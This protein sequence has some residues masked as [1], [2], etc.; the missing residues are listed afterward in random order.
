MTDPI[1]V[2]VV[3]QTPPPYHGQ[4]IMIQMLLDG[5]TPGIKL[6]HVRM[7]FSENMDQVGRFQIAKVFHLLQLILQI[8]WMR[9]RH[10]IRILY[11]PPA[12]PNTIP[13]I[14]DTILLLCTRWMFSKTVFHFQAAG[15]SELVPRLP[16]W[17]RFFVN[18]ALGHPDVA[19]QLSPLLAKDATFLQARRVYNIPNAADDHTKDFGIFSP[20]PSEPPEM[21]Q[22]APSQERQ[23][24]NR[25]LYLGTVCEAKGILVLIDACAGLLK[26]STDF[27]LHV[28]GSFQPADMERVVQERIMQ[29]G[30]TE[31]VQ[32]HGQLIGNEK[33]RMFSQTDIFCFPS[34]Y[35]SE[36]FPC[37][38]VEAMSFGLPTVSTTWRGI[39]SIVSHDETGIL[40]PPRDVGK[41]TS[42]LS[43]LIADR[44][45]RIRMGQ[46]ARL[47]YEQEFTRERHLSAMCKVFNEL[48]L[49][50][51]NK[52]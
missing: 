4:A 32:V 19:I 31:Y 29:H 37:V 43:R 46:N 8:T 20:L 10:G 13:V 35:E 28:V 49:E 25:L 18:R 5:P 14:R 38:L 30:L 26:L 33:W 1:K 15:I 42:A 22:P 6:H 12:G 41:L 23:N 48:S 50:L 7:T 44:P 16:G 27:Q 3:G 9:I 11:Y 36:G 17:L 39:P 34:H 51:S 2:L 40:V 52:E 24:W 21:H 45:L 47:R